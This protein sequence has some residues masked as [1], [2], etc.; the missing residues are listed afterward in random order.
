MKL[1]HG[2]KNFE[3]NILSYQIENA[4]NFYDANWLNVRIDASVDDFCWSAIDSC[5]LTM[6]LKELVAWLEKIESS[7]SEVES[8]DFTEGEL[9]FKYEAKKN[10]MIVFLDFN[11]HPKGDGYIYGENGDEEFKM[12]FP[13]TPSVL[14]SLISKLKLAAEKFVVRGNPS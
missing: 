4:D 10:L 13:I 5:L 6:E 9:R 8:I 2:K 3:L 14:R 11:F 12:A 7:C 1:I